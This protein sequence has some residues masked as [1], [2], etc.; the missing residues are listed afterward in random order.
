M[1]LQYVKK[2]NVRRYFNSRDKHVSMDFLVCLDK[3][4]EVKLDQAASIH[5]GGRKTVDATIAATLRLTE[6]N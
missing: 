1:A 3:F 6:K 4:I 5:N 2:A